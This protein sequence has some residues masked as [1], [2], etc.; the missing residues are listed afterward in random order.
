MSESPLQSILP[1]WLPVIVM[2]VTLLVSWGAAVAK[3]SALQSEVANLKVEITALKLESKGFDKT[4]VELQV[5]IQR[6]ETSLD[7]I[8]ERL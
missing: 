6:I 2:I 4:L 1:K 5:G 3:F 8:K 7:F